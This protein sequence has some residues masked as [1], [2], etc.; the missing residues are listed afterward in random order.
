ML[1]SLF[2]VFCSEGTKTKIKTLALVYDPLFLFKSRSNLVTS[3]EYKVLDMQ[4]SIGKI[5]RMLFDHDEFANGVV[6]ELLVLLSE[7][8]VVAGQVTQDKDRNIGFGNWYMIPAS[9]PS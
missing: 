2:G 4:S 8:I 3:L 9:C 5:L 1:E 7:D 6:D